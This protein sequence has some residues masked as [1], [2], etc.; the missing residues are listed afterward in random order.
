MCDW[1]CH[2]CGVRLDPDEKCGCGSKAQSHGHDGL[3][4]QAKRRCRV[5]RV[6]DWLF[7]GLAAWN[8]L[9]CLAMVDRLEQDITYPLIKGG[10]LIAVFLALTVLCLWLGNCY[11]EWLGRRPF[12]GG[13]K[14]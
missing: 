13:E 2:R 9:W 1:T 10:V 3:Y 8:G 14:R 5:N 12:G 4:G 6:L 11:P 7:R